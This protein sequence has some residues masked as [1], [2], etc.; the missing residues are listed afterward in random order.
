MFKFIIDN[1]DT[2]NINS[3]LLSKNNPRYTLIDD[4][5]QD[6][7]ELITRGLVRIIKNKYLMNWFIQRVIYLIY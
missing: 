5:N 6:L 7:I 1:N 2:I 4:I 3:I